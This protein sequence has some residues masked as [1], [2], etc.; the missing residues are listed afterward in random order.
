MG[1]QQNLI[2]I[3]VLRVRRRRITGRIQCVNPSKVLST[4][5]E[6]VNIDRGQILR[7]TGRGLDCIRGR[8]VVVW[9]EEAGK[10]QDTS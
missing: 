8:S 7:V 5:P 6:L 9:R 2:Q 1:H 10:K 4:V 3:S